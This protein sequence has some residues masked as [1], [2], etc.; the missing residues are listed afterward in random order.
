[1]QRQ[2]D[3]EKLEVYRTSL[4]FLVWL[5]PILRA[6]TPI[7][8]NLAEPNGKFTSADRTTIQAHPSDC[9]YENDYVVTPEN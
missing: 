4:A 6:S 8:L 5:E 3:H 1:V 2:F 7:A 9:D